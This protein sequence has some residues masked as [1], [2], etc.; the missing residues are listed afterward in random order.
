MKKDNLEQ[1]FKLKADEVKS[2][3]SD[4]VWQNIENKLPRKKTKSFQLILRS[5]AAVALVLIIST[6]VF[7]QTKNGEAINSSFEFEGPLVEIEFKSNLSPLDINIL[8]R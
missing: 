5:I 6:V 7:N 4:N 3:P 8:Y 2:S 1:H